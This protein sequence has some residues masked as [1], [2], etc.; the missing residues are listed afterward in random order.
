VF[1]VCKKVADSGD[2][3]IQK[4]GL[5]TIGIRVP[6]FAMPLSPVCLYMMDSSSHRNQIFPVGRH[7]EVRRF[8]S[9]GLRHITSVSYGHCGVLHNERHTS[10]SFGSFLCHRQAFR[11]AIYWDP[12]P[13]AVRKWWRGEG[14]T[15][16][17]W[18]DLM[19]FTPFR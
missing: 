14:G 9:P 8:V 16:V 4:Q 6:A 12:Y 7:Q 1:R 19:S 15:G 10:T 17:W 18:G 13:R 3:V 5:S 2:A 11:V